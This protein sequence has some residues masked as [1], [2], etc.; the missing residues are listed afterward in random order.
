MGRTS[1]LSFNIEGHTIVHST[2][3]SHNKKPPGARVDCA[4]GAASD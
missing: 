3:H 2:H 1:Q 4:T